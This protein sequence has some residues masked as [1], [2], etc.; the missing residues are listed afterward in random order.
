RKLLEDRFGASVIQ[1]VERP[2]IGPI[3]ADAAGAGEC[4]IP[5]A[6]MILEV[7]DPAGHPVA[8]GA[9]GELV[10]TPLYEYASPLLRLATDL[11][12]VAPSA[13]GAMLGVRQVG[14]IV[15]TV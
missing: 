11:G 14:G 9:A 12:V 5:S 1:I 3:A 2:V 13:P 4:F 8:A 6:N 7:V 15:G 10:V